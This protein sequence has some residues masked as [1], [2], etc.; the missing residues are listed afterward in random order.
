M[1]AP[2]YVRK[3]IQTMRRFYQGALTG[4]TDEQFNW[5]PPGTANSIKASLIHLLAGEDM[6][7]QRVLQGKPLLWDDEG[8][9]RKIGVETRPG[10]DQGWDAIR[11]T[12]IPLA[13]V[14][15]YAQV[16]HAATDAYLADLTP[17]ELERNVE[18]FVADARV[19]DV[20]SILAVHVAGHS[21]E[22]AALRG[23]QGVKGLP[24]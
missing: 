19:A 7:I 11:E 1:D 23:I 15:E 6:N 13:P 16:V 21:G 22:I 3:Q 20:L 2:S 18:F 24:F 17:E 8:W 4:L 10:R 5:I 12:T 14:L 9:N